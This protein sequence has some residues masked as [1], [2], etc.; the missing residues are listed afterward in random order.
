MFNNHKINT[1][2]RKAESC[3]RDMIGSA[4]LERMVPSARVIV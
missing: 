2:L 4:Y 1:A 3:N